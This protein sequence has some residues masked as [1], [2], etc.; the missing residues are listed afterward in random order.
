MIL[1]INSGFTKTQNNFNINQ[2]VIK[3][4]RISVKS[5]MMIS[6][7]YD[8]KTEILE[9]EFSEKDIYEYYAVRINIYNNFMKASSLGKY[10]H[11][12]IKNNYQFRKIR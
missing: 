5:S 10:F 7:G 8:P 12:H 4:K 1:Y 11:K 6:V 9:I 3:L 2:E